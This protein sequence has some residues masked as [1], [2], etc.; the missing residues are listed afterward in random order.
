MSEHRLPRFFRLDGV[1]SARRS[2][3]PTGPSSE[4]PGHF[5]P[6][7]LSATETKVRGRDFVNEKHDPE[8]RD[9]KK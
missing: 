6:N 2:D 7:A 8:R 5:R 4:H 3:G 1:S 9:Q